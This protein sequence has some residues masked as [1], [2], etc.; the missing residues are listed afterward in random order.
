MRIASA[1]AVL[2]S[3][4]AQRLGRKLAL[5]SAKYR[6]KS[7][8]EQPCSATA[9][10]NCSESCKACHGYRPTMYAHPL[11]APWI[12]DLPRGRTNMS[13]DG[14]HMAWPRARTCTEVVI[15]AVMVC[16]VGQGFLVSCLYICIQC[17]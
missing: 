8:L 13:D 4:V 11:S 2:F 3:G 6:S 14:K 16:S 1:A 9:R 10:R 12:A 5:A 15:C 17:S 7:G